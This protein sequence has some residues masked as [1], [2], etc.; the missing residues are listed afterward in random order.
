MLPHFGLFPLETFQIMLPDFGWMKI[1][2]F[3][4]N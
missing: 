1:K 3:A 2:D 4:V